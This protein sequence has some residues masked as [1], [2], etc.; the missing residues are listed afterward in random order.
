[1]IVKM[2]QG[3][4]DAVYD[5]LVQSFPSDE[6]RP[7]DEQKALLQNQHYTLYVERDD[8]NMKAFV[9]VWEFERFVYI[10]HFA[11][12]PRFRSSGLGSD[13]LSQLHTMSDK[14]ICLEAEPPDTEISARRINFY[15]RNGFYLND[16]PYVQPPIS[17]GKSPVP[18]MLMTSCGQSSESELNEI[19]T[20]LYTNVYGVEQDVK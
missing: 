13:I 14:K 5:I 12:A 20:T 3:D 7:Y 19:K 17:K 18:L 10:E 2:N 9:A 16:Y 6:R 11:V 15:E 8:F 1:M 4:F